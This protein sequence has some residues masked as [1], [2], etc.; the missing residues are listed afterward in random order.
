MAKYTLP[1]GTPYTN[2]ES[3]S[4]LILGAI[5]EVLGYSPN[6]VIGD[7]QGA[8]EQL[9]VVRYILPLLADCAAA[10]EVI[11]VQAFLIEHRE[12]Q[13]TSGGSTSATSYNKHNMTHE[14]SDS[15]NNV[16]LSSGDFVV[17][18]GNWLFIAMATAYRPGACHAALY[19][20]TSGARLVLGLAGYGSAADFAN[21]AAP[22]ITVQNLAAQTTL[23]LEVYTE[24]AQSG[25]GEGVAQNVNPERFAFVLGLKLS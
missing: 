19:N 21:V 10:L 22:L 18:A 6:W 23:R 14:A 11:P 7:Q 20:V 5:D 1:D 4:A 2:W 16:A 24:A 8:I 13:N 25:N 3:W 12:N 17:E 15:D 9:A